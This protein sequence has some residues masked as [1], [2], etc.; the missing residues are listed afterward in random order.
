MIRLEPMREAQELAKRQWEEQ[1]AQAAA[2]PP[3]DLEQLVKRLRKENR[4]SADPWP[5]CKKCNLPLDPTDFHWLFRSLCSS[6]G[7]DRLERL[8]R[9]AARARGRRQFVR[10]LR[11]L[12]K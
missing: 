7:L 10:A 4:A 1:E 3:A 2:E 11:R 6:H 9:K 12:A 5:V 8:A